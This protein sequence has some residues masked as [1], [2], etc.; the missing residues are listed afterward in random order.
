MKNL[1]HLSRTLK[2]L[3]CLVLLIA[4]LCSC[5]SSV[6]GDEKDPKEVSTEHNQD[7]FEDSDKEKDAKFVEQA[8]IINLTEIQLGKLAEQKGGIAE[9]RD[10]AKMILKGH[11]ASQD[12]FKS[13]A[14]VKVIT[15]PDSTTQEV[16]DAYKKLNA[17]SG[18]KFDSEFCEMMVKGH[19]EA[20]ALFEKESNETN[21]SDIKS[22]VTSTLPA[23]RVHLDRA[24]TC[25][26]NCKKVE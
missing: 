18:K 16:R 13:L 7:K 24:L 17:K 14:S 20:I 11:M 12:E 9:V 10:L 15:I 6:K 21:D 4:S 26:E 8:V 3:S 19:K 23:L 1:N 22:L 2:Q 25:E 5:N